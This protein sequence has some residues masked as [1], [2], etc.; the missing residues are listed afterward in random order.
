MSAEAP[1][2]ARVVAWQRRAGRQGLPWQG[3]R[4]PYRVWLSEIMLQQTQ[5]AT[6]LRYYERF[7][8]RFP[9]VEALAAATLDD[10]LAA[11]SGLGYYRRARL[12]H[13]AAQGIVQQ[14]G[15]RWPTDW[16]GWRTLPGVGDSTA[17]AIAAFCYGQRVSILDGNVRRVLLRWWARGPA[18]DRPITARQLWAR[19]QALL[20]ASASAAEM[21]AYTQGMMDLGATVC[22]PRQPRCDACPLRSD[23]GAHASG[24]PEAW[25]QPA[26]RPR[27]QTQDWWLLLP[28]RGDGAWWLQRRAARGIWAGLWTPPLLQG[29]ASAQVPREC[30]ALPAV[31]ALHERAVVTH[32]LTHRD[33]RLHPWVV[34]WA[35][36]GDDAPALPGVQPDQ[37]AWWSPSAALALALPA[38]LRVWFQNELSDSRTSS[39]R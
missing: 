33:L 32:A 22:T 12:L 31:A 21:A 35:A 17:A 1:L 37:G 2:F 9:S 24:T 19:A 10:V 23:C 11:W 3:T 25:P 30:G 7:V 36:T 39:S 5:V 4:D 38:P 34:E 20:P 6:V 15:G 13:D 29:P 28:V 8:A 27:R 16:E 26:T 14:R 18:P